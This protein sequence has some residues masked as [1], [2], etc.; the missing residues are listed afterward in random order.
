MAWE[1][2]LQSSDAMSLDPALQA[3]TKLKAYIAE[4]WDTS[5]HSTDASEDRKPSRDAVGWYDDEAVYVSADRLR[6]AAGGS[7]KAIEIAKALDAQGLIAKRHDARCNYVS[8]VPKIGHVKA[9]ALSRPEFGRPKSSQDQEESIT[10]KGV[11]FQDRRS[12]VQ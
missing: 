3:I 8:Y 7:L 5:I 4:R 11:K 9:Y 12:R 2:F 10:D 1:R 6:E